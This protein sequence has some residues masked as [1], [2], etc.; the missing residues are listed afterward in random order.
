MATINPQTT[1]L[2]GLEIVFVA[3]AA[4]GDVVPNDGKTILRVKNGGGSDQTVTVTATGKCNQGSLHNSVTVVT[5]GEERDIGPFPKHQ[6]DNGSGQFAVTYSG[7]TSVTVAAIK[8][9]A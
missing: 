1:S 2:T 9:A 7:V 4:G 3:A 5:A 6:F 8:P